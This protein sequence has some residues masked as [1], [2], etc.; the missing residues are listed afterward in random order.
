MEKKPEQTNVP[1][2][3]D[4]KKDQIDLDAVVRKYDAEARYRMLD[5]WRAKLVSVTAILM[6]VF[7]LYMAG[8]GTMPT[9]KQRMI[10]LAFVMFL[11]FIL[12]PARKKSDMKN[13]SP[14]DYLF[15]LAG[16]GV[17]LYMFFMIDVISNRPGA[18]I[19]QTEFLVG[20]IGGLLV[21]EAARRCIGKEL[22][23]LALIF[24]LYAYLGPYL[25][26]AIAHRGFGIKRLVEH[27]FISAEGV[28]GIALGVSSTFIFLFILFGAFLGQTGLSKLFTNISMAIA[29]HAPGGP[30]KVAVIGS[31]LMGMINGSAAAN[32][33]TT[34]AFTIPL[35]KS[36]GYRPYFAGAVEAVASTGGQIMPP[37]MGAAA[38]IMAEF[39]GIAYKEIIIVAFIPAVLYYVACWVMVDLEARKLQLKGL[40]R[41]QLPNITAELKENGHLIIPILLLIYLIMKDF[42]PTFAAFYSIICLIVVSSFRKHTRLNLLS[43]AKSLENGA[44]G[45]LGVAI[46]C[47]VVGFLVG[48]VTLT[49]LGLMLANIILTISGGLLIPTLFF[50]M[51]AC[52]ILGMGM[53]TSAAY[54]VA[55]TVAA[56][57]MVNLGVEPITAHL[58][59]LYFAVLSAITPPVALASYAGAGI[60]GADPSK[61][62]WAAV[63]LG[64]AGFIIPFMFVFSPALLMKGP[65]LD[66]LVAFA[67][68]TIG[69]ICLAGSLQGY[70]LTHAKIYERVVLFACALLLIKG[71]LETDLI[72]IGLLAVVLVMQKIRIKKAP[73]T[74]IGV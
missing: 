38:F 69:T 63:R 61:V 64:L 62:G 5:G 49:G 58:F 16:A 32:V 30:A 70:L 11:I 46:A 40:A 65:A 44:R 45:V 50:T 66:V 26:M 74:P 25:P 72:G 28:Y 29:G 3:K 13:P 37:V 21:L 23:V 60:A 55:G 47:A 67:T 8:L 2:S 1:V 10:H 33:A 39:L 36:L 54:I 51:V 56:P 24:M 20:L 22:T 6:S 59:V 68:A 27:M 52:I 71:G 35:M 15:A 31:G 9:N 4:S 41:N 53:P 7:H 57:A 42:S 19:T 48:V 73:G 43:L 17:N 34:G 12:Y 18:G 14:F